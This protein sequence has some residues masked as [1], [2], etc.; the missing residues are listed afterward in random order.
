MRKIFITLKDKNTFRENRDN[1]HKLRT[2]NEN[3]PL[4]SKNGS[5]GET[6]H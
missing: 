4:E 1:F 3:P 6:I 2:H 5:G